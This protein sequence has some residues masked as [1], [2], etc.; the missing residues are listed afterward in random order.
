MMKK[1][2][3]IGG[4][5]G[6]GK[7]TISQQLKKELDHCVFLDGDWCWDMHPFIVNDETKKM[8]MNNITYSL[9]Q[10]IHCSS[11]ENIIFCWVM[12]ENNIIEDILSLLDL[13]DCEVY[14]ISL[15]CSR[16]VLKQRIQKDIELDIRQKDVIDRSIERLSCYEKVDSFKINVSDLSVNE[17][18]KCIKQYCRL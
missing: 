17:S 14:N 15:I 12:H 5:M 9:N 7:T 8:V 3:L 6:I 11:I 18:V 2:I 13:K 1:I 4:P 10:F 16:E